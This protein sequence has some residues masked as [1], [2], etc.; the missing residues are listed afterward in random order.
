MTFLGEMTPRLV[1]RPRRSVDA[2]T[3]ARERLGFKPNEQQAAV[4]LSRSKRVIL[5]CSRQWGKSTVTAARAL[6]RAMA[7][8]GCLV[9]AASPS[10]R[11][12]AEWM[13]KAKEMA[14]HMGVATAGDGDNEV[15]LRL[16]NGSRIVGLPG[17]PDTTRGFSAVSMLV[18]DEAARVSD[19]TFESLMPMLAVSDGDIW[20]MSTP[21][22]KSG[23]FYETWE[24]GGPEW[25]RVRGPAT[26]CSQIR[27]TFLEEQRRRMT[28]DRF[29]QEYL[30]EFA[31]T[32]AG[33][34]GRDLVEAM[35]DEAVEAF[36]F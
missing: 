19:E 2:V 23:F 9:L 30:C 3:F 27:G 14:A 22:G 4:L 11:Q 13:R 34:F 20:M 15:S 28:A 25:L 32:G 24:Y 7:R 36:E 16:D 21:R 5:N 8:Q 17:V 31:G 1:Q 10:Q 29:R 12:S 18:V 35:F 33:V 6:F 26:E